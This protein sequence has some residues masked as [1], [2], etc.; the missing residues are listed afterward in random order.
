MSKNKYNSLEIEQKRM[1]CIYNEKHKRIT[2][3]QLILHFTKEFQLERPIKTS[4]MSDI[5]KNS[6]KFLRYKED[7]INKKKRI[8]IAMLPEI[9]VS[10]YMDVFKDSF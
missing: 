3:K 1:I 5:I 10:V 9:E 7:D 4:T 2:Q 8:R 6:S